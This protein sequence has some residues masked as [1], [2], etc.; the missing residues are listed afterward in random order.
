[1]KLRAVWMMLFLCLLTGAAARA[2]VLI[3]EVGASNHCAYFDALGDT[4]DWLELYNGGG[5]A[6]SL[7]GWSLS[8][9]ADGRD[10][11]PLNGTLAPGAYR[12]VD[13][14]GAAWRLS[15]AGETVYLFR[16][17]EERQRLSYPALGEDVTCALIGGE[18]ART[19]LPTP[20]AENALLGE[21][22]RYPAAEGPRF[23]EALTSGAPYKGSDGYDYVELINTGRT[24]SLKGWELRLGMAGSRACALPAEAL[25]T[26]DLMALYCEGDYILNVPNTG[27][28]L[29]AQGALLS[30]WTPQGELADFWRLPAQYPNIAYGLPSGGGAP[31]YLAAQSPGRRNGAAYPSRVE[32]PALSL[33]GGVYADESLIVSVACPAGA[34]LRYTT[35]G[36]LPGEDSPQLTGSLRLTGTVALR[37]A[38]FRAGELPSADVSAT[39]VLGMEADCPIVS[40]IIDPF[41]LNDRQNG[42][43]YGQ[44]NGVPNYKYDWE[45]PAHFEYFDADGRLLASQ[46]CGFGIQ[47]DSSRGN[48]QKAFKLKARK[49]YGGSGAFE[50]NPFAHRN[51]TSYKSFNL[52]A[53]GSE[54]E[55]GVRFRDA[56]LSSLAEG[57]SLLYAD[58]QPVLVLLN[59]EMYGHYNLRERLN[60]YCVAQHWGITDPDVIRNI[61]I[62]SETGEWT[63]NG[64]NRDYMALSRFMRAY[65]LNDPACLQY[66]LDHMDV[67][68]YFEYVAFMMCT[69]NRDLSNSRFYRIPGGKWRWMLY[70][71]DRGMEELENRA[72][73][74]LYT[75]PI[76]HEFALST[77]HVPFVALMQ[78]PVMRDYFLTVLGNVLATRFSQDAILPRIDAWHEALAP[79][80][81]I[82]LARWT[83]ETMHYWEYQVQQMRKCAQQRPAYVVHYAQQYFR[84]SDSEVQKYFGW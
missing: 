28:D 34:V 57:T 67:Q 37:V 12:L 35:N 18:Y 29:P 71:I 77:D 38:A 21:G 8:D 25:G 64:S 2:E 15:A 41:Y 78:V 17:G 79:L 19:W 60:K 56:C 43:L 82:Q 65:D 68:S 5:E 14:G 48:R 4:P 50:F 53:A 45:Y 42:L 20:G 49:A 54:G 62:L 73:F 52:R 80:M 47:G 63:R 11:L 81:P 39:Y 27:F 55:A 23:N 44:T 30:L 74:W 69:G 24:V 1:M 84:L 31:G 59:G 9:R 36:A 33:P 70:D 72:A 76:D 3:S 6:V 13:L 66:V 51:F 58:A 32:T 26:G 7:A 16:D 46:G 40:L 75:L 83:D 10:A 22:E 61:D